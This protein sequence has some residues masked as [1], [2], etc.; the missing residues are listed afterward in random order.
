MTQQRQSLV[1]DY[2][3]GVRFGYKWFDSEGKQPLFPFGYGLSYT[4]FRYTNLHVDPR[5]KPRHS[6]LKMSARAAEQRLRKSMWSCPRPA[7]SISAG[8]PAGSA[9]R[10]PRAT[11]DG[12]RSARAIGD[13]DLR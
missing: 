11:K 1:A 7:G 3:E 12:Y 6:R 4:K 5:R 8:L 2:K 10:C 13:G 9:L